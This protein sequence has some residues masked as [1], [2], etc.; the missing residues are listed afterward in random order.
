MPVIDYSETNTALGGPV[1]LSLATD[2]PKKDVSILLSQLWKE[3]YLFER[4]FSR[5]LPQ[6]E[7][8]IFNRKAGLRV[9]LSPEFRDLLKAVRHMA[10]RTNGLFNPFILPALQRAGYI[11]SASPGY[12]HDTQEDYSDRQVVAADQLTVGDTWASIPHGTA[13][14]L[15]GCGKGFLLDILD[16]IVKRHDIQGYWLSLA[17]DI[18]VW[19]RDASGDQMR[20]SVQSALDISGVSDWVVLCPDTGLSVATSGTFQRRNQ[21]RQRRWHHIID[22]STLLPAESDIL[23]ATVC[24][25]TGMDA[26]VLASCAV[27]LGSKNATTFLKRQRASSA[28]IQ[29]KIPDGS[30][31]EKRFGPLII[32]K[33]G[34]RR[35]K[36]EV[37]NV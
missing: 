18:V 9:S 23:L 28:L 19:G 11:Q 30:I 34:P 15:G 1:T 31:H 6:S 3:V 22:P 17:G 32:S 13:I 27:A 7:L 12:E 16:T 25:R 21:A 24:A 20:I 8:S 36:S 29:Y 37:H 4:R 5:F 26:D 14:D 10:I 35:M 33:R 2:M